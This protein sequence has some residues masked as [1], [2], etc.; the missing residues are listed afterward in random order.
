MSE[1]FFFPLKGLTM[2]NPEE[3]LKVNKS[4]INHSNRVMN[5]EDDEYDK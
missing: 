2:K 1:P 5:E 4:I 3:L